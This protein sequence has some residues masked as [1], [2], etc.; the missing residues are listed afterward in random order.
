MLTLPLW[1]TTL[2]VQLFPDGCLDDVCFDR[3]GLGY[4][5]FFFSRNAHVKDFSSLNSHFLLFF[6]SSSR[7][8]EK[9]SQDPAR[10]EAEREKSRERESERESTR[11]RG[12]ER[13]RERRD[14]GRRFL[15][16]QTTPS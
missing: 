13:E 8:C 7:T 1:A 15:E 16:R 9:I 4:F 14:W 11:A 10:S 5:V 2:N 12:R 3:L 6:S